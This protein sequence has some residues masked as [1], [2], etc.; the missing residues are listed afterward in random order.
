MQSIG[1]EYYS[2]KFISQSPN[3]KCAFALLLLSSIVYDTCTFPTEMLK[4][5]L[6]HHFVQM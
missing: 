2:N 4:C 1:L 6:S 3:L 5:K